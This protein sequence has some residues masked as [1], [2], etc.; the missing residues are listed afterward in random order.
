MVVC[1]KVS[2]DGGPLLPSPLGYEE[3]FPFMI[4]TAISFLSCC[5]DVIRHVVT[6]DIDLGHLPAFHLT[7]SFLPFKTLLMAKKVTASQEGRVLTAEF[8]AYRN[9]L[10]ASH[11]SA[12][13]FVWRIEQAQPP[14]GWKF[15]VVDGDAASSVPHSSHNGDNTAAGAVDWG[16]WMSHFDDWLSN[17]NGVD[18]QQYTTGAI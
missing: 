12:G 17:A 5:A 16:Y 7:L 3:R 10:I 4:E 13:D 15:A 2:N 6:S 8:T 14:S 1:L 18:I 9:L 11:P